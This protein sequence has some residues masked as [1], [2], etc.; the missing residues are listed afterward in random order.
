MG[1]G[2]PYREGQP[3]KL[4]KA[5]GVQGR[6]VMCKGSR[7]SRTTDQ[8]PI[9]L[10]LGVRPRRGVGRYTHLYLIA[11]RGAAP[12]EHDRTL[13]TATHVWEDGVRDI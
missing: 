5:L 7:Q 1:G 4:R 2:R 6:S 8:D 13:A 9:Q 3:W 11:E 10:N 12:N